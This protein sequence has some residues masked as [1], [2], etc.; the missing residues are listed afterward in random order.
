M[1]PDPPTMAR[2]YKCYKAPGTR[3]PNISWS[4]CHWTY[5]SWK[6]SGCLY[7]LLIVI[8]SFDPTQREPAIPIGEPY[9]WWVNI[10][11]FKEVVFTVWKLSFTDIF[12][13]FVYCFLEDWV[14]QVKKYLAT[15]FEKALKHS[16]AYI[17]IHFNRKL[18]K[19]DCLKIWAVLM[20]SKNSFIL[21]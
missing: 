2:T 18:I 8:L 16:N 12:S 6:F 14:F 1:P 10:S 20:L 9:S 4:V 17:F 11:S 19:M 13:I 5:S 3:P 15:M 7:L 21:H